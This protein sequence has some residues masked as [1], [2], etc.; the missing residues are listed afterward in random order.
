MFKINYLIGVQIRYKK[1]E[2]R[3]SDLK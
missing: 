2:I 1:I 3:I